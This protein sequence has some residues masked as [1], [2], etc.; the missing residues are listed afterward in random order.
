MCFALYYIIHI[1]IHIYIYV[2]LMYDTCM[3][4]ELQCFH[5]NQH[6]RILCQTCVSEK[7]H[8]LPYLTRAGAAPGPSL[9]TYLG[10]PWNLCVSTFHFVRF[11]H[12]VPALGN[13]SLRM[14]WQG[15]VAVA[16][17]F[18]RRLYV[19]QLSCREKRSCPK[20]QVHEV[21]AAIDVEYCGVQIAQISIENPAFP[22]QYSHFIDILFIYISRYEYRYRYR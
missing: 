11:V 10:N 22:K 17:Y 3:Y 16:S 8:L 15:V 9:L 19:L 6:L 14:K 2:H 13:G 7:L 12:F 4:T 5:M 20:L 18:S 21:H 1:H